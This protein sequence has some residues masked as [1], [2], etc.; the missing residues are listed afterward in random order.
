MKWKSPYR[1]TG[2]VGLIWGLIALAL[3]IDAVVNH[4]WLHLAAWFLMTFHNIN[5]V[6]FQGEEDYK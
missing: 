3:L 1:G 6:H 5:I 4:D 2:L